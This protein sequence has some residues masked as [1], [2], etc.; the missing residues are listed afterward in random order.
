MSL[1]NIAKTCYYQLPDWLLKAGGI[2]YY[3]IPERVRY[4]NV[5]SGT[6]KKI[7]EV[8]YLAQADLDKLVDEHFVFT[9]RHAYEQVPFYREY[10]D[11]YGVNI[12]SIHGV[13]DI[14]KLPFIDRDIVKKYSDKLI[15][16]DSKKKKL[17]YVT[18][19]GSTG[20]PLGFFQPDNITMQEWAYTIQI[21][22]RVGYRP[23]SSRLVLRGKKL[24]P[25]GEKQNYY[26]DPLRRE[27]SC[28]I[29]DM[30]E[31]TMDVYCQ[32]VEKYRP[33]FIHGYMSAILML[34][35]YIDQN[36][37]NI[38]HHFKA[39]LATSENV[40][41]EQKEY[42][43]KIFNTKVFSFY[44]HSERLVIA[45]ECEYSTEYHVEPLYGYCEI[46]DEQ[47]AASQFGEIVATGF[48]NN[49]MP[50]IR[51]KTG[52]MASWSQ[53]PTC[54]C[55]RCYKRLQKITGRWH[56]DMLV[57]IDKADVS[58]TALNIH[59]DAF[60]KIIRYKLVQYEIGKVEMLIQVS[61]LYLEEDQIKIKELL[62]SK[63]NHKIEFTLKIVDHLSVP[64]NGKYQIVEQHIKLE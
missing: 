64:Q 8:E 10:Y 3:M 57:N 61:N 37:I 22:E 23:N 56:Q 55:G 52:D 29:F 34:A 45:G 47:G 15:A 19:S 46:I 38:K 28:N 42:V 4:G 44:G 12:S 25:A 2:V 18:T 21:W 60:D 24:H 59:S 48:L 33:E 16:N 39:I 17:I 53:T 36:N 30:R 49:D 7:Q 63:T 11:T 40:I 26:Y 58:L 51:Y 31:E 20:T 43:E 9:V 62:E 32:A 6:L 41:D 50:L 5:F 1:F 54:K 13:K 14:N 35:K 27:L